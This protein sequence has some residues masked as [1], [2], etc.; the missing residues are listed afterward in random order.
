MLLY[1]DEFRSVERAEKA[2]FLVRIR[3]HPFPKGAGK[4]ETAGL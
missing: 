2:P 4:G 3:V 1:E